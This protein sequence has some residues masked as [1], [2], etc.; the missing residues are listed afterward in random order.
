MTTSKEITTDHIPKC[1]K[2]CKEKTGDPE[3]AQ[4]VGESLQKYRAR[5]YKETE[6]DQITLEA[7]RNVK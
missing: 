2:A 3:L 4:K 6:K 7:L 1:I 5:E